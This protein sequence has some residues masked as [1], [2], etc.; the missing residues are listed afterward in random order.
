MKVNDIRALCSKRLNLIDQLEIG[1]LTK[2]TFILENFKMLASYGDVSLTIQ[3]VDE[4]ILKYH[5]FNT[6]AKM[7]MLEAD[8]LEF[9]APDKH[10][11]LKEQAYDWYLKKD[12]I[13]LQLVELVNYEAISAYFIHMNSRGLE[14]QIYEI[15]FYNHDR[16][17]LHSKDRKILHKLKTAGCFIEERMDSKVKSYVNTKIY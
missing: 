6:Q 3:S 15:D 2:E 13:T 4:G 9:R 5:Y 17:I 1:V 7:K 12:K 8:E 11:K 10:F 14:G 16:V